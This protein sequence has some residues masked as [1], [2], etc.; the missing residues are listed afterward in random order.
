MSVFN[1]EFGNLIPDWGGED[2][3]IL[4]KSLV[5]NIESKLPS[6]RVLSYIL[7]KVSLFAISRSRLLEIANNDTFNRIIGENSKGRKN[8]QY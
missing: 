8:S 3:G 6:F 7:L 2:K 4:L 5:P 1:L